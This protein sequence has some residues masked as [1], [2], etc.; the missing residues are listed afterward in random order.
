M[1]EDAETLDL[2]SYIREY[3]RITFTSIKTPRKFFEEI[4]NEDSGYL[5]P[6][7]YM[8]ISN[9]VFTAGLFLG[10]FFYNT[11]SVALQATAFYLMGMVVYYIILAIL[12]FIFVGS[13]HLGIILVK[14]IAELNQTFKV[15]CY[16]FS[17]I[18]FAWLFIAAAIGSFNFNEIAEF[19]I[20]LLGLFASLLFILYL[21][22]KGISV[23]AYVSEAR[24][25]AALT[26]P[27]V[28]NAAIIFVLIPGLISSYDSGEK[29]I[30]I[31][32]DPSND[33]SKPILEPYKAKMEAKSEPII[34]NI[35]VF[36][37]STPD[38]DGIKD[39]KDAWYEGESVRT[40]I[41]ASYLT[42]TTKHD[43]KNI[44]ILMELNGQ[45]AVM[46]Q[47]MINFAQ[48]ESTPGPDTISRDNLS[49]ARF[50]NYYMR[51]SNVDYSFNKFDYISENIKGRYKNGIYT[52]E[53]QIPMKSGNVSSIYIDKFPTQV[54][55]SVTN[56]KNN[57]GIWPSYANPNKPQTWG[58]MTILGEK[59][60]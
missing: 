9:I 28:I 5:K 23:T 57:N 38:I 39:D 37:G 24:A 1:D 44:Y 55:F 25:S 40:A 41:G 42:I 6:F 53:Y 54:H 56:L 43:F 3:I 31:Y 7:A 35:Y 16:S 48:D 59:A 12:L 27:L 33:F 2:K 13:M 8:I 4:Q 17:P 34:H 14:G 11:A 29:S 30:P 58:N 50:D 51:F 20:F 18:N 52:L 22:V 45:P 47:T 49:T 21:A 60:R 15:I 19:I 36:A 32:S 26:V 10:F 46:D